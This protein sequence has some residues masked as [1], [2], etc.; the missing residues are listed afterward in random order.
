MGIEKILILAVIWMCVLPLLL[1]ELSALGGTQ[2]IS[3][4]TSSNGVVNYFVAGMRAQPR[5]AFA[6][7]LDLPFLEND[8]IKLI[9]YSSFRI[10]FSRITDAILE[11]VAAHQYQKVRIFAIS[12]GTAVTYSVGQR[13]AAH[14][15]KGDFT[16]ECYNINPCPSAEFLNA[17]VKKRLLELYPL[18]V[19]IVIILGPLSFIP[20]VPGLGGRS[21][22]MLMLSQVDQILYGMPRPLLN[23]HQR[24]IR[25]IILSYDDEFLDNQVVRN[26]YSFQTVKTLGKVKH[27][28]TV[29]AAAQYRQAVDCLIRSETYRQL[30]EQDADQ[31]RLDPR[32]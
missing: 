12:V 21:S 4:K 27:S 3:H 28:D 13:M 9:P 22:L 2:M 31:R 25:G 24:Y 30:A 23:G 29:G 18:A 10:R 11:D 16:L 7:M 6:F 5:Q 26:L 14:Q 20:I 15:V 8:T 1:I 19:A 32:E 17:K